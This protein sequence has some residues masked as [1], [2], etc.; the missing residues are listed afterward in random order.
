MRYSISEIGT[1]ETL[2]LFTGLGSENSENSR[3][4]SLKLRESLTGGRK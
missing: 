3:S 1:S 2:K 4:V